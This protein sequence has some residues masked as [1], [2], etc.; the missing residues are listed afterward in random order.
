MYPKKY[1]NIVNCAS[2]I[3]PLEQE[4][5]P[6]LLILAWGRCSNGQCGRYWNSCVF[7]HFSVGVQFRA[8]VL[9]S[10]SF[11]SLFN[12]AWNEL[13]KVFTLVKQCDRACVLVN[14]PP[15]STWVGGGVVI[16][17]RSQDTELQLVP[18]SP[19]YGAQPLFAPDS[20]VKQHKLGGN[21]LP[22]L[23]IWR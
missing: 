17:G 10:F 1:F 20:C 16:V 4:W 6:L 5:K 3:S 15:V 18:T 14:F 11:K 12:V 2:S 19:G 22:N 13:F 9:S 8:P 23:K 21:K 7:Y